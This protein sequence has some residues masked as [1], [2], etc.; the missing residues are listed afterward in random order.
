MYLPLALVC[1]HSKHPQTLEKGV[2][3]ASMEDCAALAWNQFHLLFRDKILD[4]VAAFP[5]DAKDNKTNE[6]FWS[7]HKK[8]P[9]ALE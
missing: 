9:K 1:T 4:L 5:E 6:P 7:G 2:S 3:G 8:Y